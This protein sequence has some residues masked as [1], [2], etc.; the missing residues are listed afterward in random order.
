MVKFKK[1]LK[2][3][4]IFLP[5]VVF[6]SCSETIS[7]AETLLASK[8]DKDS[9]YVIIDENTKSFTLDLSASR[10]EKIEKS[11]FFSLKSRFYQKVNS[12]IDVKKSTDQE[13]DKKM[14]LK[15]LI[16]ILWK[17]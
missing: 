12:Q 2:L 4:P 14:S 10:L 3:S 5:L 9:P 7:Q 13:K 8:N 16:F 6:L 15:K 11:A 1:F 17:K